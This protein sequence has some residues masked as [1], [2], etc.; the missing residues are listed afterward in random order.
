MGLGMV[1]KGLGVGVGVGGGGKR[2]ELAQHSAFGTPVPPI[3]MAQPNSAFAA[4]EILHFGAGS[5]RYLI[6]HLL[7]GQFFYYLS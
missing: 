4:L 6:R 7:Q 3:P 1:G 2:I 5:L